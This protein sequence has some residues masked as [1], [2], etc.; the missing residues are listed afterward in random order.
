VVH[1]NEAN[2]EDSAKHRTME[3]TCTGWSC[4]NIVGATELYIFVGKTE[5]H[6]SKVKHRE[7]KIYTI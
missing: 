2:D 4:C 3:W 6:F 1:M 5:L 7:H